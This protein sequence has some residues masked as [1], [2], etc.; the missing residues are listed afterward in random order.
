MASSPTSA[1]STESAGRFTLGPDCCSGFRDVCAALHVTPFS[2]SQL[3]RSISS[4]IKIDNKTRIVKEK[5]VICRVARDIAEA[6]T[7]VC[8]GLQGDSGGLGVRLGRL[9]FE[10]F[11]GLAG[12]Q[13]L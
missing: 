11:P 5:G 6:R 4:R 12:G 7:T 8:F 13:L 1:C 9:G 10:M 3:V 2:Y